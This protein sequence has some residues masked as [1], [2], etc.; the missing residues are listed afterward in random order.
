LKITNGKSLI[1]NPYS[2]SLILFQVANLLPTQSPIVIQP[3]LFPPP[4]A[5]PA[6]SPAAAKLFDIQ[7]ENIIRLA[8]GN[9]AKVSVK[10]QD[11]K[12][13]GQAEMPV[14]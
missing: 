7:G 14:S 6:L 1:H 4:A 12:T 13:L 10:P 2:F 9:P 5:N 3:T 11:P 8:P